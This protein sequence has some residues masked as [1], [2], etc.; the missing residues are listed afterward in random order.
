MQ[1]QTPV[2]AVQLNHTV[3]HATDRQLSA[4]FIAVVLG[5]KPGAP[6]GPFLPVDLGNS[7]TLDSYEQ[8]DAEPIQ[9][10]HHT[11]LRQACPLPGPRR[12]GRPTEAKRAR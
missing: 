10:Q 4:E 11:A 8:R 9:P 3:V 1:M 5:L 2:T 12:H 7:V 6:F